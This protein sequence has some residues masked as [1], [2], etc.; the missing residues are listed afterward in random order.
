MKINLNRNFGYYNLDKDTPLD[1]IV[2]LMK[3]CGKT[4][5]KEKIEKKF[6][7]VKK[8]LEEYEEFVF[9]KENYEKEE[10]SKISCYVSD[11]EEPWSEEN[12]T[13][14]FEHV[15]NFSNNFKYQKKNIQLFTLHSP[16]LDTGQVPLDE[17]PRPTHELEQQHLL[18]K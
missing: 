5:E 4:I 12:L 18:Y 15:L 16:V 6:E 9:L 7:K 14:A 11:T 8:Y 3:T 13:K 10:L 2:F 1:L 17:T